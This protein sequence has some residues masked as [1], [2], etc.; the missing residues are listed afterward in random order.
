MHWLKSPHEALA[1]I[2]AVT[3][4]DAIFSNNPSIFRIG[5]ISEVSAIALINLLIVDVVTFLNLGKSMS[6]QQVLATAKLI[7][8]D[9]STKNL[10]PDDFKICFENAKKGYYGRSFD[11]VDGQIVFEWLNAY[12]VERMDVHENLAQQLHDE[13]KKGIINPN[14]INREGQKKVIEILKSVT[15]KSTDVKKEKPKPIKTERDI[16][17]QNCFKEHYEFWLKKPVEN[18]IGRFIEFNGEF[19]DEVEYAKIKLNEYE[20]NK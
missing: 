19:I 16:F 13:R 17:I 2:S 11:R 7:L 15:E 1:N 12:M 14:E 18:V 5:L 10:K 8:K 3:I 20:N 6:A 9:K 4:K